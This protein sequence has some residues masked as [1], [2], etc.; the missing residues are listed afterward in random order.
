MCVSGGEPMTLSC[1]DIGTRAALSLQELNRE[2]LENPHV[3]LPALGCSGLLQIG[4]RFLARP[5]IGFDLIRDLL[6]FRETA[7]ARALN[8]ADVDEHILSA[9]VGLNE[10]V[11]F[12]LVEPLD[13]TCRHGS[14]LEHEGALPV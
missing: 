1:F 8:R 12:L 9:A 6:P 13:R 3:E 14:S 4:G 10:A 11:A 5:A 7:Q 2:A